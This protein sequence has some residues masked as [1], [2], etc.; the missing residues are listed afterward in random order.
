MKIMV[1]G[2][3]TAGL[4]AAGVLF[5]LAACGSSRSSDFGDG[6]GDD[7]G[8][9]GALGFGSSGGSSGGDAHACQGLECQVQS[10]GG[11]SETSI[12]G[13]AF[14]PNGTLPLYDV[15]VYVPN[16]KPDDLVQGVTCDQCGAVTGNPVTTALSDATGKFVLHNAPVGDN[17]PLVLQVGKWRR[18]VTIPHVA[19]CTENALTDHELTRLP[20]NQTEG[21]MPHIA[22][23]SGGCDLLGCVLPKIGIDASEF[24]KDGDGY[25]KAVHVYTGG[26]GGTGSM[27]DATTL[28]N[29]VNKLK[30]YDMAILSCECSENLGNKGGASGPAFDA[31]TQYMN[32]GGRI[33]TSDY[34]YSWYRYTKDNGLKSAVNLRGGAPPGGD[35]MTIDTT[36]AKGKALGDWL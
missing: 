29:D 26:G 22:L 35:P 9:S 2:G 19:A 11:G 10:C 3:L 25:A 14:A 36:F 15:V 20:K 7:G 24:G 33:F 8:S 13:T 4:L 34:M 23:T 18:Q 27:P 30:T 12:T 32:A 1:R 31:I 28:W 21:N 16:S 6:S 5:I 17:I